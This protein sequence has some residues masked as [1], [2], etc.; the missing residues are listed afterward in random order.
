MKIK[1]QASRRV[2]E[3]YVANIITMFQSASEEQEQAGRAW[4]PTAHR[5]ADMMTDGDVRLGAGLLAALSPQTTWDLN[6]RL[7]CDA[8]DTGRPAGHFGD[9]LSKA[10]RIL[11]GLP[12]ESVLPMQRKTGHFYRCIVDP[13]D[14]DAVCVDRHA[15]DAAVG[16]VYGSA[17]R[18][19][20]AAG[21]YNLIAD[22]YREAARRLGEIPQVVQAVT[23]VVWKDAA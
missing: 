6:V 9:A 21:R 8:F 4:Y 7:A 5:I 23:W 3:Q 14:K 2:R 16:T 12:P 17:D 20:G 13:S 10:T 1:I 15:H 18:G 11:A 22:A 19:L